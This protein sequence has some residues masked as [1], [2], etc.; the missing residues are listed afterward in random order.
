MGDAFV[1]AVLARLDVSAERRGPATL[2]RRIAFNRLRL[3]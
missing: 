3:T 1:R 2:D